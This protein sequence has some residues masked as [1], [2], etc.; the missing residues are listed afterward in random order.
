M[1]AYNAKAGGKSL[2][3][4]LHDITQTEHASAGACTATRLQFGGVFVAR[5]GLPDGPEW[6]KLVSVTRTL[7][8]C[9]CKGYGYRH[10]SKH[11][12]SSAMIHKD[13]TITVLILEELCYLAFHARC[14]RH[15]RDV[16]GEGESALSRRFFIRPRCHLITTKRRFQRKI[17]KCR[18][19]ATLFVTGMPSIFLCRLG[20]PGRTFTLRLESGAWSSQPI[21]GGVSWSTCVFCL[22]DGLALCRCDFENHSSVFACVCLLASM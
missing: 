3:Q 6:P 22:D 1:S 2:S 4:F 15:A 13:G 21:H 5:R 20:S 16:H 17:S 10:H 19:R 8:R 14:Q 12:P 7:P 18:N 9:P 11:S